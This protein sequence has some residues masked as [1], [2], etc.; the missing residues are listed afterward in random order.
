ME[1][2]ITVIFIFIL[3]LML[4]MLLSLIIENDIFVDHGVNGYTQNTSVFDNSSEGD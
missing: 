3:T 1:R 2:K 4:L